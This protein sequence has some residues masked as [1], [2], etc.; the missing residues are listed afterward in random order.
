MFYFTREHVALPTLRCFPSVTIFP[1]IS[2]GGRCSRIFVNLHRKNHFKYEKE[3]A[4]LF[5]HLFTADLLH[6]VRLILIS[7]AERSPTS[8]KIETIQFA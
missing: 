3:P 6:Q 5:S 8:P 7:I 4:L 1:Q 2:E